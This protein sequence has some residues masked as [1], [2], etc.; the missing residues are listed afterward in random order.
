[1]PTRRSYRRFGLTATFYTGGSVQ[2]IYFKKFRYVRLTSN[3]I[4]SICGISIVEDYYRW[5]KFNVMEIA[6]IKE[7]KKALFSFSAESLSTILSVLVFGGL[8]ARLI[9]F[10]DASLGSTYPL[11]GSFT[12]S[13][14]I[15]QL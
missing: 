4:Q 1:M 13:E 14:T 8:V 2:G 5:H 3:S 6:Y 12:G 10:L 15:L 9:Q 11:I 7:D